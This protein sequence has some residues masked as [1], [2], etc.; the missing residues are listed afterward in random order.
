[1]SYIY[2]NNV[3]LVMLF[4]ILFRHD[5]GFIN[6]LDVPAW[7]YFMNSFAL[8][9]EDDLTFFKLFENLNEIKYKI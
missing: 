5:S 9:Y 7:T 4:Y 8:C 3:K 1:M 2:V 6:H